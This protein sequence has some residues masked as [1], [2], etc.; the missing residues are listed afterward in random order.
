[1]DSG[2]AR[3]DARPGMT[4]PFPGR[5]APHA[6]IPRCALLGAGPESITPNRV[7]FSGR[8]AAHPG[9]RF[10][11]P[12]HRLRSCEALLRRAG[13]LPSTALCTTPALQL[14]APQE[15]RAALR[16]GN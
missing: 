4:L 10:A 9:P 11:R 1:M 13:I 5:D 12:E 8:D 14:T 6:V 16:P 15:L 2:F 3:E 7:S